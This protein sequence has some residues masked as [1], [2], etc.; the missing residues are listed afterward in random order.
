MSDLALKDACNQR[1]ISIQSTPITQNINSALQ[2]LLL[3]SF[4][5]ALNLIPFSFFNFWQN[6]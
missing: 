2:D 3:L 1:Q 4:Y 5:I 6:K